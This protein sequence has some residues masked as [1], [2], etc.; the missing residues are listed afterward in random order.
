MKNAI[1]CFRRNG[2]NIVLAYFINGGLNIAHLR[3]EVN[4]GYRVIGGVEH[5][6]FG[7]GTCAFVPA[8]TRF[9]FTRGELE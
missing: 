6:R 7:A 1:E 3:D 2:D 4:N 5:Y 9:E 8:L